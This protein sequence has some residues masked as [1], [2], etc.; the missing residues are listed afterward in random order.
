MQSES[1]LHRLFLGLTSCT[2]LPSR[3]KRCG[4]VEGVSVPP[5]SGLLA[6]CF[7]LTEAGRL[8]LVWMVLIRRE[9]SP[10]R[11]DLGRRRNDQT[12]EPARQGWHPWIM[13][14]ALRVREE[15]KNSAYSFNLQ[16]IGL[17][18]GV[19]EVRRGEYGVL[20]RFATAWPPNSVSS[21]SSRGRCRFRLRRLIL[22]VFWIV[23]GGEVQL[24]SMSFQFAAAL[25]TS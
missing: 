8:G 14:S 23:V 11:I 4:D 5:L 18:L 10:C 7:S 1:G 21:S 24:L 19:G 13:P 17:P 2:R 22:P 16:G 25:R 20:L 12:F 9:W 3:C 6:K 15:P